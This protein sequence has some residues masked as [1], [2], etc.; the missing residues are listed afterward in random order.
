[1]ATRHQAR[2]AVISLLYAHDMGN[3]KSIVNADNYL[4][5]E[6]IR[7]KQNEFAKS[8][9][10]GVDKNREKIDSI[11]I[12]NLQNWSF[13]KLGRVEKSILRVSTYELLY[14]DTD[15]GIIINEAIEASKKLADPKSPSFI[16]GILDNI[17][18]LRG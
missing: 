18:T 15:F 4:L 9:L 1:M 6:K 3:E 5:E 11:I 7:G 16:N 10:A 13:D 12:D 14:T 8:L 17:K 2:L